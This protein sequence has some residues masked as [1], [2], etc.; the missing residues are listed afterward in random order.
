MKKILSLFIAFLLFSISYANDNQEQTTTIESWLVAGPFALPM[1][2]FHEKPD[3]AGETFGMKQLLESVQLPSQTRIEAGHPALSRLDESIRWQSATVNDSAEMLLNKTQSK[4]HEFY[5]LATYLEIS[6]FTPMQLEVFSEP[7]FELYLNGTKKGGRNSMQKSRDKNPVNTEL[8]LEPGKH[9]LIIKTLLPPDSLRPFPLKVNAKYDKVFENMQWS[10]L[11]EHKMN[12][13]RVLEGKRI[14][15]LQLSPNGN[16]YLI[17]LSETMP[18]EG[19]TESWYELYETESNTLIRNFRHAR[20]RQ[21]RFHPDGEQLSFIAGESG[22]QKLILLHIEKGIQTTIFEIPEN[23]GGYHWSPD[24]KQI[25]YSTSHKDEKEANANLRKVRG[26]PD[27]WPW[28]RTRSQLHLLNLKTAFSTPLTHG[29]LSSNFHD[30]SPD[31]NKILISQSEPDFSERPY[32]RQRLMELNL[33]TNQPDTIW[34]KHYSVSASYS[35][36]GKSLLLTGS[37]ALFGDAGVNLTDTSR[38]PSD[39]DTQAYIYHLENGNVDAITFNYDPKILKAQW[40]HFD[41]KIYF[42]TE[43]KTRKNL[44]FWIS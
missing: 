11:P 43:D 22:N 10:L 28:W 1:P 29:Y 41:D 4:Q 24:G 35:P 6:R 9:L 39:Y 44:A 40:S 7:A 3:L 21:G 33:H 18:P 23:F 27:R 38:I 37:P 12:M 31:G 25:V 14:R 2:A 32:S 13:E 42:R 36:D 19:K 20:L 17:G 8:K 30:F 16:Y 15:S 5:F 26:M 34:E